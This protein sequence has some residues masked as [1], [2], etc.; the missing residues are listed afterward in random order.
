MIKI[1]KYKKT[2]EGYLRQWHHTNYRVR[3][4]QIIGNWLGIP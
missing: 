2:S 3:T 1:K 4:L